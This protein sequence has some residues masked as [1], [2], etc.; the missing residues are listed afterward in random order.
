PGDDLAG[1]MVVTISGSTSALPGTVAGSA[2][3]TPLDRFPAKGRGTGGVRAQR[4]VRGE[5]C[6][7][8]A[9]VGQQPLR[10]MDSNGK[11][12]DLPDIDERRDASGS[13]MTAIVHSVG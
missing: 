13:G 8:L 3:V 11:P 9:Y 10:A 12:V 7:Q 1:S 4:F 6:L 2:K 5:D